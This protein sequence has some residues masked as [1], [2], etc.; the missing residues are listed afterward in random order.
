LRRRSAPRG[1]DKLSVDDI[2]QMRIHGSREFIRE[3]R[4]LSYK[5]LGVDGVVKLRIHGASVSFIREMRDLGYK[6]LA[7]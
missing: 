6:D 1:L 4:D 3:L 5:D 2:I 7:L